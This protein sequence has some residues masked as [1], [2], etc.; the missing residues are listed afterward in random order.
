MN[1][2]EKIKAIIINYIDEALGELER[3][4]ELSD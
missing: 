1:D 2:E 4:K 3:L